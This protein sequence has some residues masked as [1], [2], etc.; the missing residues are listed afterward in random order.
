MCGGETESIVI[1]GVVA[2]MR[3]RGVVDEGRSIVVVVVA[4]VGPLGGLVELVRRRAIEKGARTGGGGGEPG[5]NEGG[6][7]EVALGDV[8][9]R[10]GGI[11]IGNW[12]LGIE[13]V[14]LLRRIAAGRGGEDVAVEGHVAGGFQLASEG[15]AGGGLCDWR[16]GQ[17]E[18]EKRK[19][20]LLLGQ[21]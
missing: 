4:G 9:L 17:E 7:G 14:Y 20:P 16:Q 10:E 13:N 21:L 6:A 3:K 15:A 12:E 18:E 11:R 5:D 2:Q 1:L 19:H 8:H